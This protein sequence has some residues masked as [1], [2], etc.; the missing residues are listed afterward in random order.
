MAS[1]VFTSYAQADRDKALE[2]FVWEFRNTLGGFQGVNGDEERQ[3]LAFFDRDLPGGEKWS[4]A[5]LE[6]V[7]E[8]GVLVCLV[9]HTYLRRPWCGRELQVFLERSKALPVGT[10]ARFIFPI[11]WQ[12]PKKPRPLPSRLDQWNW[13]DPS[14]PKRYVEGGVWNLE[15]KGWRKDFLAMA[16]RLAELVHEALETATPLPAGAVINNIEDIL[17]AFDE[18]QD[19]DARLL[20]LTTNGDAWQPGP[21]DVSVARAAE[22][23]SRRLEIFVRPLDH[24]AGLEAGLHKAQTEQQIIV[25]VLDAKLA[26]TAALATVNRLN[27]PNLAVLLVE[28]AVPLRGAEAWLASTGL[29]SGSLAAAKDVGLFRV[30]APGALAA[31]MQILLDAAGTRLS[32]VP[33]PA[34]ADD[35]DLASRVRA[36]KGIDVTA[37][38]HLAGP[39]DGGPR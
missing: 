4:A 11:W 2:K 31:E 33:K 35:P 25:V 8:A 32:A 14:Y 30:A 3:K 1:P 39:G 12:K 29:P 19:F 9:S 34:K 38:P 24:A 21:T 27:L 23:A 7:R 26:P 20:A 28:S 5:I 18:Q 17:N 16:D 36:E 37:Q 22:D 6:A 10:Q 15:R 13:R